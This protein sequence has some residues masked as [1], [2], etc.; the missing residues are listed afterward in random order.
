M[1]NFFKIFYL[2]I[3]HLF[4]IAGFVFVGVFFAIRFKWTN[5]S[6]SVDVMSNTFQEQADQVKTLGETNINMDSINEITKLSQTRSEKIKL[7][8]ELN[9]L[10]YVTPINVKK[11]MEAR[12]TGTG[13]DG[14]TKKMIFAVKTKMGNTSDLDISV[15][16]CMESFDSS[17][18][19]ETE[20]LSRMINVEGVDI[21]GW[22]NHKEW[23]D[24]KQAISKDEAV[25]KR[26]AAMVEM[27]PRLIVSDLMVEQL[28][29]YF[30]IRE[31]YKQYFEPL[32][33]LS[34]SNK[35]SL[36][37]MSIKEETAINVEKHL[38]DKSSPYYLGEKYEHLLD[39][40][41]SD[42]SKIR[43]ERLMDNT[44]YYSYLYAAIYLK[45][46]M[47]QWSDAG[48]SIDDRPE[49]VC[50]LFNVG[51]PQSKPNAT[52]KV[53]GSNIKI[54]TETY[55]FGRLGFEFF[56]SG[57]LMGQFPYLNK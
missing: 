52:P 11:I 45:Q 26:A 21:F 33:I 57:E 12:K 14:L 40:E 8:C 41:S 9:E 16:K 36:G 53:G 18:I 25:I 39:Y 3:L 34:N 30:S 23:Q 51:F 4:A 31:L 5:V 38:K 17:P 28:R 55:S 56:Y 32:K 15:K 47:K 13:G 6:G 29:L 27:D 43:Y 44:H 24:A 20:I 19:S 49:I 46:M 22:V 1:K 54:G 37:V 2:V 50:T 10:S 7:M 48:F 42:T 35:I